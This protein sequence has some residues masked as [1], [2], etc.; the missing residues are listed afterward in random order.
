LV[1][2]GFHF[3]ESPHQN[4]K[5]LG[6]AFWRIAAAMGD[7]DADV[8][9]SLMEYQFDSIGNHASSDARK[10]I[11]DI[12]VGRKN[13]LARTFDARN[14]SRDG[15]HNEAL[16]VA[17]EVCR[18]TECGPAGPDETEIASPR[19]LPWKTWSEVLD[20]TDVHDKLL[21]FEYGA[22]VWDDPEACEKHARS[23]HVEEG[24]DYWLK[25]ATKAAMAGN[26]GLIQKVGLYYLAL[27]GW[28]PRKEQVSKAF[29]SKIGFAW[30][31]MS[32]MFLEPRL[33]AR[34]WCGLA[35]LLREHGDKA[36]GMHY[37]QEG[38]KQVEGNQVS[39]S[40][41]SKTE[42]F[43]ELRALVRQWGV[44]DMHKQGQRVSSNLFLDPPIIPVP[45]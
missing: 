4:W 41:D 42:A 8:L 37:L 13:W 45:G 39:E 3:Y 27:H 38:L 36:R 17:M 35:V 9:L 32:T 25:Y 19:P 5:S 28:Y 30:L 12:A 1:I 43:T 26:T 7:R 14:L 33:A 16:A 40:D 24:T 21:A 22:A 20:P 44:A 23:E 15:Y 11:A 31:E 18:S 34:T 29:D 10:A 2:L 6:L